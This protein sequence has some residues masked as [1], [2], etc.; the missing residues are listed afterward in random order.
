[1]K[2]T[3]ITAALLSAAAAMQAA[4]PY[5]ETLDRGMVAV[6]SGRGSFVSWRSLEQDPEAL[7]F[8]VYRDGQ[9][10]T[11][12]PITR[13][14]NYYD[15]AGKAGS[16]YV[17]KALLGGEVV[18]TTPEITSVADEFLRVHLDRPEGGTTPDKVSYT[19]EPND[20][21]VGDVDG[22]GRYEIFV[23]WNPTNSHDNS[24]G[25]Y[26]G[27]VFIDCYTLDG[28]RLWRVDLG[29]NI[30]AGAHY[31]Q[32]MVFD[33]DGDGHAE[34]ACKTAPG[35]IDGAG[36]PVL[37]GDNKVTD[38]YRSSKSGSSKGQVISGPEYLTMF[39]GRTGA[40]LS[41]VAYEPGRDVRTSS[42]WGDSYGGR[43]ERYLA[44]VAYL[45]GVKPSLVMCRGYYTAAYLCAWDFDGKNLKKRWLHKSEKSGEGLYGEGAHSLTVGDVDGDGCD[46]I[47]YG[48]ACLDHDGTVL[49]RTGGGHGDALH[50]GDFDPDRPGLEVFM[51]HEEKKKKYDCEFR[52][53]A[54][55]KIIWSVANSGNDIGRGLVADLS[56]HWR[57]HEVWPGSHFDSN[58]ERSDVTFDNKGNII[59]QKRASSN[60]RIY[61]DGDLLDELFD[62]RYDKDLKAY[63]PVIT[64]RSA[65]L[66]SDSQSWFFA[67]H[68]G[69][70]CNTTKA[71]PCLQADIL[72]DWREELV[73]WDRD[74]ASDLL[75]FTTTIASSYRVPCL[76]QDHNYRLAIAWQNVGY[77][78]PPHLGYNLAATFNTDAG[79]TADAPGTDRS[80]E[81]GHAMEPVTGSWKNATGVAASGLPEGVSLIA[82]NTAR[83]FVIEGT[84]AAAGKYKYS[85]ATQGGTT[86]AFLT[87]TIT[88][89]EPVE[90]KPLAA[91]T[92]DEFGATVPN[93]VEGA[94][95]VHGAPASADG[96]SAAAIKL[97]GTADYLTQDA[98][99]AMQLGRRD[100]TIEFWLNSTDDAAYIFHKGSMT[101]SESAGT[102]GCWTGI[103]YKKGELRFAID[104]NVAKSEAKVSA[105]GVFDGAWHH[106]VAVRDNA[107]SSLMIYIDGVL[108]ASAGDTTGDI[109]D[110][111]E[112]MVIGNV[113][114][115][116]DNPLAGCLDELVVYEGAMSPGM[117][118]ER[119]D[120]RPSAG[121]GKP[122]VQGEGPVRLTL[123]DARTGI[124]VARGVGHSSNVTATAAP[125]IY[126]LAEEQSGTTRYT[127]IV[128]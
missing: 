47:V 121:I 81:R 13:G 63:A 86:D 113:N 7:V 124:V 98:Y 62:G 89:S 55:G 37:M 110:N 14:T 24:E 75:I 119:Y 83:T 20:C 127:K 94:A 11:S 45:D 36:N 8:D 97:D 50:L 73:L 18:E 59:A 31:T 66:T 41:T 77:N 87:G 22:D 84:P 85:V 102:S 51:V 107:S 43:S 12:E 6:A 42:Q 120:S 106:I 112:A 104:D 103:E 39:D 58:G 118:R 15:R 126:I 74:T 30:R 67:K 96:I 4:A 27:N 48:S 46:E 101:A 2:K 100:F 16:K 40:A 35:T 3:I 32:F 72:G 56:K 92:F 117:V 65:D 5:A 71:T 99:P 57:G 21:S 29:R 91:F 105:T 52:D 61:W 70:A 123:I 38:D 54:T 90:L 25:G 114:T 49:Y 68:G 82:D 19:Y 88:V 78:Q 64:K 76:M 69:A 125:G 10:I 80:V 17:V 93:L 122:A 115:G 111:N 33:F 109:S 116:F 53:A 95:T 28:E 26:T 79:I 23:K 1:M 128:L 9:K 34:M 44:A 60:F 108:M